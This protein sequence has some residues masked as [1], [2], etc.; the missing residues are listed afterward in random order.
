MKDESKDFLI[1]EFRFLAASKQHNA[2][3]SLGLLSLVLTIATATVAATVVFIVETD[4]TLRSALVVVMLVAVLNFVASWP[5][6]QRAHDLLFQSRSSSRAM[7]AI[8]AYF[9]KNEPSIV[10]AL[11]MPTDPDYPDFFRL[12]PGLGR[13]SWMGPAGQSLSIAV[14]SAGVLAGSASFLLLEVVGQAYEEV[15]VVVAVAAGVLTGWVAHSSAKKVAAEVE[16]RVRKD[17]ELTVGR[18]GNV[19]SEPATSD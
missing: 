1:E 2:T 9:A 5:A 19:A 10:E 18:F 13:S 16:L 4:P 3:Y 8:R 12:G 17:Y 14:T 11:R 7:N 6:S 15:A